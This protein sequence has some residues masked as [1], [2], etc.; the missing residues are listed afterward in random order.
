[1]NYPKQGT[2][3]LWGTAGD[4][5]YS[6]AKQWTILDISLVYLSPSLFSV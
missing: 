6:K 4:L 1:M 5:I 3:Q 2:N